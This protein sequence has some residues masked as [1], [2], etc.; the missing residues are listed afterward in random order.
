MGTNNKKPII[1]ISAVNFSI[2]GPLSILRDCLIALNT[3]FLEQYEVVA[4]VHKKNTFEVEFPNIILLEFPKIKSSWFRRLRFEYFTCYQLS[5]K[6]KPF[7]W[8]SLHDITPNVIAS[9]RAVYCHNPSPFYKTSI[10]EAKIE[11]PFFLFSKFYRW[12]YKINIKK[13]NYVIVQQ[14]WTREYFKKNYGVQNVIVAQPGEKVFKNFKKTEKG[15]NV[16]FKFFFPALPRVFKN[17]EIV[18]EA[19]K[20]LNNTR[21][22]FEMI[23]TILEKD[24]KY[25]NFLFNKYGTISNLNLI[26]VQD[27]EKVMAMYANVDCLIFPSKLETWGLPITEAKGFDLPILVA[28]LPYAHETIGNYN[29]VTF[30]KTDDAIA[31]CILMDKIIDG[32]LIFDG[33]KK[34]MPEPLFTDNWASLLN[35]LLTD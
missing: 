3:Y 31:L 35:I 9:R 4:I 21:N 18:Y 1:V 30:F 2:G 15:S 12:L 13:N 11:L 34:L 29:N 8:L 33:S 22:D 5:K 6:I 10:F 17:F 32:K 25:T 16:K 23:L 19:V 24:N 14:Q 7:L 20:L 26:G 28:D 27:Q